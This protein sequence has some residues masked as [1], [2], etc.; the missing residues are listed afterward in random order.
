MHLHGSYPT[1]TS[2]GCENEKHGVSE[3]EERISTHIDV[4]G[5][6]SS[7]RV[8]QAERGSDEL[9]SEA[10]ELLRLAAL[11]EDIPVARAF[12]EAVLAESAVGWHALAVLQNKPHAART[13]VEL[14]IGV[15]EKA[16]LASARR[17]AAPGKDS[18]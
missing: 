1:S 6:I 15:V 14:A 8:P 12:A 17:R 10:R 3:A 9:A 16:C 5:R 13:L 18:K 11:R 4:S 2:S 7:G